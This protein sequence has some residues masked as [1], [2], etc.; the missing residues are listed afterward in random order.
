MQ[1]KAAENDCFGYPISSTSFIGELENSKTISNM[2]KEY[3]DKLRVILF[4]KGDLKFLLLEAE[5]IQD[6]ELYV[7]EWGKDKEFRRIEMERNNLN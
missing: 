6:S 2:K 3:I 1:V 7:I 5:N 4:Q